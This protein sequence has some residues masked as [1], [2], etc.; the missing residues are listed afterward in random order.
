MALPMMN[1]IEFGAAPQMAD[2]TSNQKTAARN[3]AFTF[4]KVAYFAEYEQEGA[5]GQ[6]VRGAV[7]ANIVRG[8]EI[9]RDLWNCCSDDK[10][11]LPERQFDYL[12]SIKA[13]AP[14]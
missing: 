2:P 8:L 4:K 12:Q 11:V 3:A 10:F 9:I 13:N 5:V 7:P 14:R 1:A 6:E